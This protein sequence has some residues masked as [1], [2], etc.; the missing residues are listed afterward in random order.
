MA[1][2]F[3]DLKLRSRRA[4]HE[5]MKVRAI[6]YAGPGATPAFIHVRPHTAPKM[7][8]DMKGTNLSYGEIHESPTTVVFDVAEVGKVIPRNSLVIITIDEAFLVDNDLPV[9][10][11]TTTAEVK[12]APPE[13][14]IGKLLPDGPTL[15]ACTVITEDMVHIPG[16]EVGGP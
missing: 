7:Q 10:N 2:S 8:G 4:L 16:T 5:A 1:E 14:L 3:R 11:I 12:P 9:Y 15:D 6:Y 13:T